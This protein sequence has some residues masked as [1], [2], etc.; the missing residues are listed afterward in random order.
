MEEAMF[1]RR[2]YTMIK[3]IFLIA[4][5]LNGLIYDPGDI[6]VNIM[7]EK[8]LEGFFN[9]N[10][11]KPKYSKDIEKKF[12]IFIDSFTET[13][14]KKNLFVWSGDITGIGKKEVIFIKYKNID[15]FGID[16]EY[17][18]IWEY[19]ESE[20][21]REFEEK[22][23]K[24]EDGEKWWYYYTKI[25]SYEFGGKKT[26]YK[27]DYY[28]LEI[29][30][31]EG[32]G[33]LNIKIIEYSPNIF[34]KIKEPP[35]KALIALI[36]YSKWLNSYT[37]IDSSSQQLVPN[38]DFKLFFRFNYPDNSDEWTDEMK[39]KFDEMIKNERWDFIHKG[40][41][42]KKGGYSVLFINYSTTTCRGKLEMTLND[43]KVIEWKDNKWVERFKI[44][45]DKM[46]VDSVYHPEYTPLICEEG[47]V[48]DMKY[49]DV[50]FSFDYSG[51]MDIIF[52]Q[53]CERKTGNQDITYMP[54]WDKFDGIDMRDPFGT[55]EDKRLGRT[56]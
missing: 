9:D 55:E 21:E 35:I 15:A 4:M 11:P 14:G 6:E 12:D 26:K 48:C 20:F 45:G 13:I 54:S 22:L 31:L 37:Y 47:S 5:S 19:N 40:D 39:Q 51:K 29:S 52:F 16:A 17:I 1:C 38:E 44:E 2:R 46:Y 36:T 10:F 25:E 56:P 23:I 42:L 50:E 28:D 7:S 8:M 41:I 33:K 27:L 43:L 53:G 34:R 30:K 18:G 49:Y 24:E 32:G 3:F